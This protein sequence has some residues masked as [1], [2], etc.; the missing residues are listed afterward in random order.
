MQTPSRLTFAAALIGL[1][2]L[3]FVYGDFT[4]QWQPVP[5]W[6]PDRRLLA[7]LSASI[8]L[9]CGGALHTPRARGA[10]V[11]FLFV[12]LGAPA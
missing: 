9:A 12:A 5:P 3:T 1:A 4:L 2:A 7:Y 8:L 11:L 6:V 10:R